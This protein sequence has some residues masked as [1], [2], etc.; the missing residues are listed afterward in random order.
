MWYE[1]KDRYVRVPVPKSFDTLVENLQNRD[2][3]LWSSI[4]LPTLKSTQSPSKCDEE[5]SLFSL[6]D[7][8]S[9]SDDLVT[10]EPVDFERER[11]LNRIRD[12]EQQN[13]EKDSLISTLQTEVKKLRQ[14]ANEKRRV[15]TQNGANPR[16]VEFYR[17]RYEM[18]RTQFERLKEALAAGGKMKRVP[19]SSV[20]TV[21]L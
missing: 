4:S 13:R 15:M 14:I 19:A 6:N 2:S 9:D 21:K 16:D 20:R 17:E 12:L 10:P 11:L 7:S 18:M 8:F 1:E 3:V 5:K